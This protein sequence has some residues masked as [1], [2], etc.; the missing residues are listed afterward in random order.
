[1]SKSKAPTIARYGINWSLFGNGGDFSRLD[2]GKA[3][4]I[5]MSAAHAKEHNA[6]K[7]RS[8]DIIRSPFF[9]MLYQVIHPCPTAALASKL[10]S[11]PSKSAS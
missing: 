10:S 3:N 2:Y 11:K 7:S 8:F 6:P 4:L 5:N 1:M 9:S